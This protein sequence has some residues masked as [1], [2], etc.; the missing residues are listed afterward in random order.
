MRVASR[1]APRRFG[2]ARKS[3][4]ARAR[5]AR[6]DGQHLVG[7]VEHR[8]AVGQVVEVAHEDDAVPP[9]PPSVQACYG[10]EHKRCETPLYTFTRDDTFDLSLY[11]FFDSLFIRPV[12]FTR[13]YDSYCSSFFYSTT[14]F[15]L[16]GESNEWMMGTVG[17]LD[18]TS[19]CCI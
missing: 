11:D 12:S 2:R 16:R 17:R 13:T 7:K 8:V 18:G 9:P 15:F 10:G 1:R 4:V 3:S 5:R 14:L 19:P 6:H